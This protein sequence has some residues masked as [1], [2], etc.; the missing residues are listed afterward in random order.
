MVEAKHLRRS[1]L[2]ILAGTVVG[3]AIGYAYAVAT[4]RIAGPVAYGQFALVFSLVSIAT[5]FATLGLSRSVVRFVGMYAANRKAARLRGTVSVLGVFLAFTS[6]CVALIVALLAPVLASRYLNDGSLTHVVRISAWLIPL[7]VLTNFVLDVLRGLR[8]AEYRTYV[9]S[10]V[11][12]PLRMALLPTIGP[13]STA[14]VQLMMIELAAAVT[15]LLVAVGFFWRKFNPLIASSGMAVPVKEIL[16]FSLP[17]VPA[18]LLLAFGYQTETLVLGLLGYTT[19]AGMLNAALR[20]ASFGSIVLLA[21]NSN[22]APLISG[23]R[24]TGEITSLAMLFRKLTYWQMMIMVGWCGLIILLSKD[25]LQLF[26]GDFV[27]ARFAL[28]LLALRQVTDTILGPVGLM[29][30]MGGWGMLT[31]FNTTIYLGLSIVFDVLFIPRWGTTGAALSVLV[32]SILL[33]TFVSIQVWRFYK[34]HALSAR[35]IWL[36][37]LGLGVVPLVMIGRSVFLTN[38][39]WWLQV[40]VVAVLYSLVYCGIVALLMTT[41]EREWLSVS[42]QHAARAGIRGLIGGS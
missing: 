39:P 19:E 5:A 37:L 24:D 4:A 3:Q 32:T 25:I 22:F 12:K 34:T 28:I 33:N 31:L 15:G 27:E 10:F 40:S 1:S 7:I 14:L 42:V 41:S 21:F 9:E 38:C 35:S 11:Q 17:M 8:M 36:T 2:I 29:I 20:T 13:T 30:T 6:V 18:S 23:L 16:R 26:G